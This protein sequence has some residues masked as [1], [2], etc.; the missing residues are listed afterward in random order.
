M[1]KIHKILVIALIVIALVVVDLLPSGVA[2]ADQ[3]CKTNKVSLSSC[4]VTSYPLKNGF[5]I[6]THMNGPVY[7]EKKEFQLHGA[8]PDTRF[9]LYREFPENVYIPGTPIVI[10][11]AGTL[12]PA[13]GSIYT[14]KHGNGHITTNQPPHAP[15]LIG[16]MSLGIDHLT[17]KNVLIEVVDG[18]LIPAYESEILTTYLDSKW[19]LDPPTP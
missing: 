7:F 9:V 16:L 3:T 15:N 6:S 18:E 17:F 2:F 5:V 13:E 4:D 10:I 8:K 12:A 19:T 1:K 14:D 11:P